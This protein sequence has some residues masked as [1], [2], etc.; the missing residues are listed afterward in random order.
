MLG[1]V[2]SLAPADSLELPANIPFFFL[3]SGDD[4]ASFGRSVD[5][6]SDHSYIAL[7][8]QW[9]NIYEIAAKK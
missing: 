3:T 7:Y 9:N 4:S 2:H 8:C 5:P 1:E 6:P